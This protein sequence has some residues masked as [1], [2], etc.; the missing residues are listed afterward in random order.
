MFK[1]W[2]IWKIGRNTGKHRKDHCENEKVENNYL[3]PWW[4]QEFSRND[5]KMLSTQKTDTFY[6]T[7][8]LT[9]FKIHF[10]DEKYVWQEEK[11]GWHD[12]LDKGL[13]YTVY[14]TSLT[15]W[16]LTTQQKKIKDFNIH[17]PKEVKWIWHNQMKRNKY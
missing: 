10:K 3:W 6:W 16:K 2:N 1:S 8:L 9:P 11:N 7:I 5:T 13:I 4:R 14:K 12:L 15:L 17:C